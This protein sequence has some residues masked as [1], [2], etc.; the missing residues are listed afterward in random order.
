MRSIH[1]VLSFL[2][3]AT[4]AQ[5]TVIYDNTTI[6]GFG[7]AGG[8]ATMLNGSLVTNVVADDITPAAGSAGMGVTSFTYSIQNFNSVVVTTSPIISFWAGAAGVDEPGTLLAT[9]TISPITI[10]AGSKSVFTDS[11]PTAFFTVPSG[12]FWAGESFSD[13]GGTTG[14]TAG[15]LN[16][17]GLTI[18]GPPAIGSSQDLFFLATPDQQGSNDPIGGLFFFSGQPVAN[19]AW[20]FS[21]TS[22]PEPASVLL[23]VGGFG[24]LAGVARRQRLN[25]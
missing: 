5:A 24:L 25:R 12:L 23:M 8:G 21:A 20:Q 1:I 4:C 19:F 14:A 15:E 11:S 10:A 6:L 18:A 3:F 17:L 22:A 7:Y 2:V 16:N 9:I 13:F